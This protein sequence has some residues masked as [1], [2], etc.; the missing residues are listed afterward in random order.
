MADE[1]GLGAWVDGQKAAGTT[2]S[3]EQSF[4]LDASK[5]WSK[6]VGL[7][8][9]GLRA[10][11]LGTKHPFAVRYPEGF[12]EQWDGSAMG[13]RSA[14]PAG[15]FEITITH[16]PQGQRDLT[17]FK[18]AAVRAEIGRTL[19][20][21]CFCSPVPI[22][23][24]KLSVSE[25]LHDPNC[26]V[27]R[28]RP[29]L[30]RRLPLSDRI[31]AFVLPNNRSQFRA[32]MH[33]YL[34]NQDSEWHVDEVLGKDLLQGGEAEAV[35]IVAYGGS[36]LQKNELHFAFLRS[37]VVIHRD[38]YSLGY[39]LAVTILLSADGLQ[40]DL[41]G[42]RLVEC[43]DV[44]VRC[45]SVL[46]ALIA[47]LDSEEGVEMSASAIPRYPKQPVAAS[48]AVY[49]GLGTLAGGAIGF[50]MTTVHGVGIAGAH[51]FGHWSEQ[52]AIRRFGKKFS[53]TELA[54]KLR[55]VRVEPTEEKRRTVRQRCGR[56]DRSWE[57]ER[58]GGR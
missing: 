42:F 9:S 34:L 32:R 5:A 30:C 33:G 27:P 46:D 37:G 43:E 50:L 12:Q 7:L 22:V 21:Y 4:T 3:E 52:S 13:L 25:L 58:W 8:A 47:L 41:S 55:E 57:S 38:S 18:L 17:G 45:R 48:L 29:I 56:R 10:L 11:A 28:A 6:L 54:D 16:L 20:K 31:P 2:A 53:T 23:C 15:S 35:A 36:E 44:R 26:G 40:A 49:V 1:T 51:G 24:D 39:P 19:T 14:A